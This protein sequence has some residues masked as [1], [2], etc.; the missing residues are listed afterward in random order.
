MGNPAKSAFCYSNGVR[1]LSYPFLDGGPMHAVQYTTTDGHTPC[2]YYDTIQQADGGA[3][4]F[5]FT[6][7]DGDDKPIGTVT[8]TFTNNVADPGSIATC[9]DGNSFSIN[10]NGAG[11]MRLTTAQCTTG[12][13]P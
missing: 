6:Y 13:C 4:T 2:Y 12:T 3:G 8:G 1:E 7:Y 9:P 5:S 11:C 10:L